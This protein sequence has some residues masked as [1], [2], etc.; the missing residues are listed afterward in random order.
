MQARRLTGSGVRFVEAASACQLR[1]VG[2]TFGAGV[3]VRWGCAPG[4]RPLPRQVQWSRGGQGEWLSGCLGRVWS[5][6][7]L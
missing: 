1:L 2:S 3:L 4:E 5:V 7:L 6:V